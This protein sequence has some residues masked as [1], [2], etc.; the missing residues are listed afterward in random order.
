[1]LC[2]GCVVQALAFCGS[3]VPASA[4]HTGPALPPSH[5][6]TCHQ[7]RCS[8]GLSGAAG[9]ARLS[10]LALAGALR[11]LWCGVL[12]WLFCVQ[13]VM[14]PEFSAEGVANAMAH[15]LEAASRA[16]AAGHAPAAPAAPAAH[17]HA[18]APHR[19]A[20]REL[21][22][23]HRSDLVLLVSN[24]EQRLLATAFAVRPDKL[25]LAPFYFDAGAD[26]ARSATPPFADRK[27]FVSIGNWQHKP[28]ADGM[29]WLKQMWPLIRRRLP[30]AELHSF[31]AYCRPH[32][33]ELT[34]KRSGFFVRGALV[35]DVMAH[36]PAYRVLLAPLRFG[37][38]IKGKV[39]DGWRAGCAVL[40]TRIGSEGLCDDACTNQC[41]PTT[42]C[43]KFGGVVADDPEQF[44]EAAVELYTNAERWHQAR[45]R[46]HHLLR[47]RFSW[48]ANAPRLVEAIESALHGIASGTG[49]RRTDYTSALV[50]AGQH[51]ETFSRYIQSKKQV[52]KLEQQLLELQRNASNPVP[53]AS[54]AAASSPVPPTATS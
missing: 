44:A 23:V 53:A 25:A 15:P 45:A 50:W 12:C 22:S 26:I 35:G 6:R 29:R 10:L 18:P 21:S 47:S 14:R 3:V 38:G 30:D 17:A 24:F 51:T 41:T 37:A 9:R 46:A 27:H 19:A 54:P 1:V 32:D 2:V 49:P 11:V 5:A 4:G 20:L 34:D 7:N 40:T 52:Q 28:N 42:D 43:C 33:L 31:G 48:D 16:A 39:V 8:A 13:A 36:L